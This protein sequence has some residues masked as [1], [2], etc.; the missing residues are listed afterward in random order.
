MVKL[1]S[2]L[3]SYRTKVYALKDIAILVRTNW[4]G[5]LVADTLLEY[6]KEHPSD[7]YRYD[8]ISDDALFVSSSATV[9]FS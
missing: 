9:R 3:N 4:K 5:P 1:P 7:R 8:I 2:I 6:K